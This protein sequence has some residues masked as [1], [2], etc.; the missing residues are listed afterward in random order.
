MSRRYLVLAPLI[1]AF[2]LT[3]C[4]DKRGSG[5]TFHKTLGRGGLVGFDKSTTKDCLNLLDVKKTIA[6]QTEGAAVHSRDYDL[7]DLIAPEIPRTIAFLTAKDE[8]TRRVLKHRTLTGANAPMFTSTSTG[9]ELLALEPV[10]ALMNVDAQTACTAV[11]FKS[12]SEFAVKYADAR[13]LRLANVKTGE[14]REYILSNNDL[15]VNVF[16]PVKLDTCEGQPSPAKF[17]RISSRLTWGPATGSIK[18][19]G[20]YAK[21]LGLNAESSSVRFQ[22]ILKTLP[23]KAEAVACGVR[24]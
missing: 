10:A 12:G 23:A 11:K 6:A 22:E 16:A 17:E 8:P 7:G 20:A 1:A 4:G 5:T 24:E 3:A 15:V 18:M 19:V 14:L 13:T 9:Q 21:R 2:A